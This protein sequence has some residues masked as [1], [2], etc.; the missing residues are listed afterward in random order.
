[1]GKERRKRKRKEKGG[2]RS[3]QQQQPPPPSERRLFDYSSASCFRLDKILAELRATARW[4]ETDV[5][6]LFGG[7][8]V[9]VLLEKRVESSTRK[10]EHVGRL[11]GAIARTRFAFFL[12]ISPSNQPYLLLGGELGSGG[13]GECLDV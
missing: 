10:E 12:L 1:M 6:L 7:R 8:S 9:Q 3:K 13:H 2:E 11:I 4:T 5:L